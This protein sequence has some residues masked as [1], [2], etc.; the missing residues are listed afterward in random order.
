LR[1]Y[2]QNDPTP[3]TLKDALAFGA[4]SRV[5]RWAPG[6]RMSYCNSG[7][8]VL[9]A[10]IE[11]VSGQRFEDYVQEH[12][13]NPLHM[14][15][16]SY[17]Y[18]ADVEKH[19]TRLYH[20]DG[21]TPNPYWHIDL[22]PAGSI[23]ASAK[24][25]ANY[26]RF[27]LQRGSFDGTQ[28]LEPSSIERMETTETLPAA[29]LGNFAGYGLYNYATCDGPF[30]FRGHNGAV[31]GG[32]TEM[33]YL[34]DYGRG[35]A[36]M[37]N[38][39]N[40]KALN[41]IAKLVRHYVIRD[42]TPPT[43]PPVAPS[44][45]ELRQHYAGYYQ[46]ISPR[47]QWTYGL[48]RLF[49]IRSLALTTNGFWTALYGVHRERWVPIS[50]RLFRKNDESAATFAL[51]PDA[52][53]G[54]RIQI[55]FATYQKVSAFRIWG[56]AAAIGAILLILFSSIVFAL[57]RRVLKWFGKSFDTAP[58]PVR[59]LRLL[60]ILFLVI[61]FGLFLIKRGDVWT[62]G[63]CSWVSVGIFLSSIAFPLTAAASLSAV[64]RARSVAMNRIVYR[65]SV[66]VAIAVT[67]I[68]VYFGYW[69][70]IGLRLWA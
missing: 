29:K 9:A 6:T 44:P 36:V 61:F 48:M 13:F 20:N 5:S 8:A 18:T 53:G 28:L 34:S 60:S 3:V 33:A 65:Q 70:F 17:F 56:Q 42:L 38:S 11:K 7:P 51:L 54:T 39:G 55:G 47:V 27:Y 24:D 59:V 40:I 15:T 68:A 23:N 31:M 58:L 49:G 62:L 63:T 37:I 50:E 67:A 19:L 66:L 46:D 14:D 52:E 4:S 32:L 69:G 22:R 43:L 35:Y 64:F 1:E 10:V 26:V 57:V 30:T 16:A 21:V 12:F 45:T 41:Q 2:A 25:M